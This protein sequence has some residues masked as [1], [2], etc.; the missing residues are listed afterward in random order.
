M[1]FFKKKNKCQRFFT[2]EKKEL[3][4]SG[5]VQFKMSLTEI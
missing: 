4:I 1:W 3:N 2:Y 5:R